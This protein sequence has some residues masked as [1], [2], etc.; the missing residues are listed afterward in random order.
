MSGLV[1]IYSKDG[2]KLNTIGEKEILGETSTILNL[3][4]SVTAKAG[5]NGATALYINLRKLHSLLR[6]NVAL[7]AIIEKTQLRLIDS[8]KQSEELSNILT[9]TIEKIQK[10]KKS[11]KELTRIITEVKDTLTA[12]ATSNLD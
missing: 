3:K 12:L 2:L 10:G 8:N 4:R 6:Q 11:P 7:A 9:D 1:E 5:K